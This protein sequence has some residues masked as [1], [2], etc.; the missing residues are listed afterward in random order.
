MC[1]YF[2]QKKSCLV[3][4]YLILLDYQNFLSEKIPAGKIK[5]TIDKIKENVYVKN[6]VTCF[7]TLCGYFFLCVYLYVI[8]K[9][10]PISMG[11]FYTE[12]LIRYSKVGRSIVP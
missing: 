7:S 10:W 5:M 6:F 3:Q 2:F 1:A 4:A 9:L 12:M 8:W 11:S